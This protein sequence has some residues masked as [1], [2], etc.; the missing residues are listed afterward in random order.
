MTLPVPLE[1]R[2]WKSVRRLERE[3]KMEW[4]SPLEHVLMK[5]G[6]QKGIQQGLEQGREEGAAMLL[7]KI[8]TQRFGPLPPP[9]TGNL[10]KPASSN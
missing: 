10:Q 5:K 8:L 7:E 3:R 4:I 2:Y 9:R 6:L 1:E